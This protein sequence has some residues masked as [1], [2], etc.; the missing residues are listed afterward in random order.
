MDIA[1]RK[2]NRLD[3]DETVFFKRQLEYVKSRTY[4]TKYKE[5]RAFRFLPVSGEAPSGATEITWRSFSQYGMAKII[6][7]Y[8]HDF[9]RVDV[10]G[11]EQTIKIRDIGD[12]YGYSIQEIRRAMMAGFDLENRRALTARRAIEQ[13]IHSIALDGDANYN[14]QG[15]IDYPGVNEYVVPAGAGGDT[16][17]STKTADEILTDLNG[18]VTTIIEITA[19]RERPNTILLPIGQYELIR[20]TRVG[21]ASD[22]TVL[23]FFRD[24]NPDIAVDWLQELDEA[25]DPDTDSNATDRMIAYTRDEEHVTLEIP[26]SF[27]QLEEEHKGME[28]TIPCHAQCAGVIVYY[29][30]SVCIADGI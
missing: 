22:T 16:E 4:D 28:Y 15:F 2:V 21:T 7:D 18:V 30:L 29:P 17:W 3:A 12:S 6:A 20:N 19:G 9:P 25:G 23:K 10:Y 11:E 5:L 27:E 8:A 13:R 26:M 14:L 1:N 24:N